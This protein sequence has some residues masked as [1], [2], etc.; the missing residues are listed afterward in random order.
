MGMGFVSVAADR[1]IWVKIDGDYVCGSHLKIPAVTGSRSV[2]AV[3]T[4]TGEE[5]VN[6]VKVE[7]NMTTPVVP[8]FFG[9][10]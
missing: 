3:D 5:Y 9:H 8:E 1:P 4:R 7:P 2:A 6:I 10:H